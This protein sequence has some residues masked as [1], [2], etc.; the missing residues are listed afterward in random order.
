MSQKE[1]TVC[2]TG[3]RKL[4]SGENLVKLKEKLENE[5]IIVLK[6]GYETFL[7]GG[8]LGW[9]MLCAEVMLSIKKRFPISTIHVVAVIPFRDQEKIWSSDD[10]KRYVSILS[11]CDEILVLNEKYHAQCYKV[12]NQFMINQ[13]TRVIGYY[14]GEFRTGTGQTV[15]MAEA[16]NIK[17]V[18]LYE[19]G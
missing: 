15:R 18:N 16:R 12:R 3:H 4:P 14:S 2:F 9:D 6:E 17:V 19:N 11:E 5:I 8:A 7:F 13:S 10:Q 1:K